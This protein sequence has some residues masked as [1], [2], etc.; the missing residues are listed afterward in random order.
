M[1]AGRNY[2][3]LSSFTCLT[4]KAFTIHLLLS[5]PYSRV[6]TEPCQVLGV[7]QSGYFDRSPQKRSKS[8]LH[9]HMI[10]ELGTRSVSCQLLSSIQNGSLADN[11]GSKDPFEHECRDKMLRE[12]CKLTKEMPQLS[13]SGTSRS[14][15]RGISI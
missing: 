15:T 10:V 5:R 2:R 7:S 8:A 11:E 4:P 6:A 1:L 13:Y 14:S 9:P 3:S 12:E